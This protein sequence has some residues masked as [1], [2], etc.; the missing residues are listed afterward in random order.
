MEMIQIKNGSAELTKQA[1]ASILETE[2]EIK[3]LK[4][5]SEELKKQLLDAMLTNNIC[6]FETPELTVQ[7]IAPTFR[8]TFDSKGFRKHCPELYDE[9]CKISPVKASV[10]FTIR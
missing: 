10:R 5:K 3:R 6:R 8:E 4:E 1:L 7:F 9:Y 2:R